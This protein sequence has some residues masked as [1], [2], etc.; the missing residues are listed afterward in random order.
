MSAA[1]PTPS[2]PVPPPAA[3]PTGTPPLLP[4]GPVP[5]PVETPHHHQKTEAELAALEIQD[6]ALYRGLK[7]FWAK[8]KTGDLLPS[9]ALAVIVVLA[10]AGG[11]WW[12]FSGQSLKAD[13]RRWAGLHNLT[14]DDRL[15][16]FATENPDTT[17]A[18]LARRSRALN[19]LGPEGTDRLSTRS[20]AEWKKAVGNIEAARDELVTLADLFRKDRSLKAACFRDAAVA[21]RALIGVPKKGPPDE[22]PANQR[23]SA[24]KV[25]DLYRQAA[26]A[27][28]ANTA[29]G[30]KYTKEAAAVETSAATILATNAYLYSR[31]MPEGISDAPAGPAPVPGTNPS[32]GANPDPKTPSTTRTP[33]TARTPSTGK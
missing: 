10:V 14:T 23:G 9:K 17:P 21:E 20:A 28:G 2:G 16:T 18:L 5:P 3:P 7:A 26:A 32:P 22:N 4:T 8:A 25:A 13:S 15:N 27:I 1:T 6:N 19:L 31:V 12:W 29:S 11:L 30:E 33:S 24:A